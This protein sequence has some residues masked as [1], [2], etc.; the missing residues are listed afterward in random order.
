ME[1]TYDLLWHDLIQ[2]RAGK[3]G[4]AD[5]TIMPKIMRELAPGGTFFDPRVVW[6][7]E[8]NR[9]LAAAEEEKR[10]QEE[11]GKARQEE[12]KRQE[13][14]QNRLKKLSL[15]DDGAGAGGAGAAEDAAGGARAP[16]PAEGG[17]MK[18]RQ[19]LAT[20]MAQARNTV[21]TEYDPEDSKTDDVFNDFVGKLEKLW[22]DSA[23]A[24]TKSQKTECEKKLEKLAKAALKQ[25][26]EAKED[27][28]G[29]KGGDKKK[30]DMIREKLEAKK[31]VDDVEDDA[32]I[33]RNTLSKFKRSLV[34][35]LMGLKDNLKSPHGRLQWMLEVIK[36]GL[37]Q[38]PRDDVLILDC[39]FA[40]IEMPMFVA[41][42]KE[43]KQREKEK[44]KAK[45][46]AKYVSPTY[47]SIRK[48]TPISVRGR[49]IHPL[50]HPP[51]HLPGRKRT[52]KGRGRRRRRTRRRRTRGR[53]P[54]GHPCRGKASWWRSSARRSTK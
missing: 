35:S 29:G 45:E 24:S 36:A 50:T 6:E 22:G 23:K 4:E 11:A 34:P 44:K 51:T 39:L 13:R 47:P 15:K 31:Q 7:A 43:V 26:K 52:R 28:K 54:R 14:L 20:K 46:A 16:S 2:H 30:S 10:R 8:Q 38:R 9:V 42:R 41:A 33:L 21:E 12:E 27:E 48:S 17:D 25:L 18:W 40:L 37:V 19:E 53:M 49:V 32:Q 3:G 1:R 5:K